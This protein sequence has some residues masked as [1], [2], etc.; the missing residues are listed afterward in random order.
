LIT[1]DFVFNDLSK[2][3][4]KPELDQI[5]GA[6]PFLNRFVIRRVQTRYEI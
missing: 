5:A 2:I 6:R 4:T 3:W 1:D